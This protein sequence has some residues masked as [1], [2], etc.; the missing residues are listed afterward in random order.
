MHKVAKLRQM[1]GPWQQQA[2]VEALLKLPETRK[3]RLINQIICKRQH[4]EF[5]I[6]FIVYFI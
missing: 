6:K 4:A 5:D 2:N 3:R 1:T